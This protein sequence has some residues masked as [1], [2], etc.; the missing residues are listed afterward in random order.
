MS[1]DPTK[2]LNDLIHYI[3]GFVPAYPDLIQGADKEK[4][5]EL[6]GL[7]SRPLPAFYREFLCRMGGDMGGFQIYESD[8]SIDAVLEYYCNEEW[9]HPSHPERYIF[10]AQ[11]QGIASLDLWLDLQ[12]LQGSEPWVV[13]FSGEAEIRQ[14]EIE[15]DTPSFRDLLFRAAVQQFRMSKSL[16]PFQDWL[17]PSMRAGY[18]EPGWR[19]QA[20]GRLK[21]VALNLGFKRAD[22][23][24]PWTLY[25]ERGDA[26]LM[27]RLWNGQL[28]TGVATATKT[29]AEKKRLQELLLDH[30]RLAP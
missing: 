19:D 23:V 13:R 4:I 12:P 5:R 8:F 28:L 14:E 24:G 7:V 15:V 30:L 3:A 2:S 16:L 18:A 11:D 26:A 17:A 9:P 27:A 10:I 20:I 1:N 29:E 6:E 21:E 22:F 25:Y